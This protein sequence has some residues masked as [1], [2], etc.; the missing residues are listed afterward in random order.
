MYFFPHLFIFSI[1]YTFINFHFYLFP[2][3]FMQICIYVYIYLC[4]ISTFLC[5]YVNEGECFTAEWQCWIFEA[6]ATPCGV[7]KRNARG[8]WTLQITQGTTYACFT[9][10]PVASVCICSVLMLTDEMEDRRYKSNITFNVNLYCINLTQT[11]TCR[12]LLAD[13]VLYLKV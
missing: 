6:T 5:R 4:I 8:L 9:H 10:T 7:I 12:H 1:I 2:H 11:V 3:L 13:L